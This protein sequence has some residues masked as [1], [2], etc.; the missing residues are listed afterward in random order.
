MIFYKKPFILNDEIENKDIKT[1]IKIFRTGNFHEAQ[2]NLKLIDKNLLKGNEIEEY[3]KL[4]KMLSIDKAGIFAVTFLL[5]V[6]LFLFID[7]I[8]K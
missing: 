7:F 3:E 4:K 2:K 1:T 5:T 6:I 8:G